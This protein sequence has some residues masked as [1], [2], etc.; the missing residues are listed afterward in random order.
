L[1]TTRR[2]VLPHPNHQNRLSQERVIKKKRKKNK[3]INKQQMKNSVLGMMEPCLKALRTKVIMD[4]GISE[5]SLIWMLILKPSL[6]YMSDVDVNN[7][8][9]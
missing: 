7:K 9:L 5:E 2:A 8:N 4:M 3:Q 1:N 6:K